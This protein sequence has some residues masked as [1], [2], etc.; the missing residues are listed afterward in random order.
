MAVTRV[1]LFTLF[2]ALLDPGTA[3]SETEVADSENVA[4][5]ELVKKEADYGL[6]QKTE[7]E[8]TV[9]TYFDCADVTWKSLNPDGNGAT[10]AQED[11]G[12]GSLKQTITCPV[13]SDQAR[14]ELVTPP[15]S[16]AAI[17]CTKETGKYDN[18]LA[19]CQETNP[20]STGTGMQKMVVANSAEQPAPCTAEAT[21][22]YSIAI[23]KEKL[24][25][26]N[27]VYCGFRHQ[28]TCLDDGTCTLDTD[29][30]DC[31][32]ED[33]K[34]ILEY[35]VNLTPGVWTLTERYPLIVLKGKIQFWSCS[36]DY[37]KS[38]P[39]EA[40]PGS[41]QPTLKSDVTHI[42][43][44]DR[45]IT[46]ERLPPREIKTVASETTSTIATSKSA[47]KDIT[48]GYPNTPDKVGES[49]KCYNY[50]WDATDWVKQT[51]GTT[52]HRLEDTAIK[53]NMPGTAADADYSFLNNGCGPCA[54]DAANNT[55]VECDTDSCNEENSATI[56]TAT[57]LPLIT[58]IYSLVMPGTAADADYS[59]PDNGCGPCA[60]N[61]TTDTCVECDTDE[62]N[63]ATTNTAVLLPLIAVIYSLVM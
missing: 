48:R 35:F 2:V 3:N 38:S 1:V 17:T 44:L 30:T 51:E 32:Y 47:R 5:A 31:R 40:Q 22:E 18:S 26:P 8:L 9:T 19:R 20:L 57:F 37:N 46:E 49:F 11:L 54:T 34:V 52:C 61:A 50:T 16:A 12:D 41:S 33:G 42:T 55:C 63:S 45:A 4:K 14:F 25:S 29:K 21:G 58:V 59:F 39:T 62:C 36:N 10:I 23:M 60:T 6:A 28:V 7:K 24:N 15:G 53:C 43:E 13:N 56:F 27:D